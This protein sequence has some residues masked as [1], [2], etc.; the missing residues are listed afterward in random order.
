MTFGR[1]EPVDQ[2]TLNNLPNELILQIIDDL[3]LQDAIP[4]LRVNK[5]LNQLVKDSSVWKQFGA[6]DFT[7]FFTQ[8]KALDVRA[9]KVIINNNMTFKI[10]HD[11]LQINGSIYDSSIENLEICRKLNEI[12][13]LFGKYNQEFG[14][15]YNQEFVFL[16]EI[17][18]GRTTFSAI[19]LIPSKA[20]YFIVTS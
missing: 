4:F 1:I 8:M 7:D 2:L 12:N 19:D 9:R 5:Q 18:I 20:L 3:D 17:L 10:Y 11:L 15:K 16:E 6:E 13:P 14:G